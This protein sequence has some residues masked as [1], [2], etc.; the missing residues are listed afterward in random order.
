MTGIL[1]H[2]AQI[3][4]DTLDGYKLTDQVGCLLSLIF[5]HV[6]AAT[7]N[8]MSS[9]DYLMHQIIASIPRQWEMT[10]GLVELERMPTSSTPN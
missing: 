2:D 3:I 1:E 7:N 8:D 10:K 6:M 4:I 5:S 9:A